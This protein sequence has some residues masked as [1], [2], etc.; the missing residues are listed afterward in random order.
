M[1]AP[2]RHIRAVDLLPQADQDQRR[3]AHLLPR[4]HA[5]GPGSRRLQEAHGLLH[6]QQVHPPLLRRTRP[7]RVPAVHQEHG[8]L[9]Q[10]DFRR[11][12]RQAPPRVRSLPVRPSRRAGGRQDLRRRLRRLRSR[13]A[14]HPGGPAHSSLHRLRQRG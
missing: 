8:H 10:P 1:P 2:R 13:R 5:R 14:H 4:E 3:L 6:R 9:H 7:R 11:V 12:P